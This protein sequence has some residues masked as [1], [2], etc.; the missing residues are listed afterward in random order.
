MNKLSIAIAALAV[1]GCGSYS[2]KTESDRLHE[3]LTD[4]KLKIEKNNTGQSYAVDQL[5]NANKGL[6][7]RVVKLEILASGLETTLRHLDEQ[8][9]TLAAAQ[10]AGAGRASTDPTGAKPPAAPAKKLEDILLDIETT[11]GQLRDQKIKADEA[12]VLLKPWARHAIPRLLEELDRSLTRFDYAKQL[13]KVLAAMPAA[14]L[15]LPLRDAAGRRSVRESAARVVGQT[16][17]KELSKILEEHAASPDEDFRLAAGEAL[18]LCRNAA[19]IPPL[20]QC[21][22]SDQGATRTIA[23]SALRKANRG[24]DFKYRPQLSPAE[25]AASIKSWE[26]WAAEYGKT[27]FD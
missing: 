24:E 1:A 25:N 5:I 26:D 21:L 11:V 18:V 7:E 2:E 10:A 20:L 27:I 19:G 3:E 13:E 14:D 22:K 17:D 9:R 8:V 16:K 15:K 6:V 12:A 4:L 23:A